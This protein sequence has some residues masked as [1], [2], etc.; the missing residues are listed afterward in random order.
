M[1]HSLSSKTN[2]RTKQEFY[3][4]KQYHFC[5]QAP[6][7]LTQNERSSEEL[8][9][10]P[11]NHYNTQT[12][13]LTDMKSKKIQLLQYLIIIILLLTNA[14]WTGIGWLIWSCSFL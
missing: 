11:H 6:L 3:D 7:Q 1:F 5:P 10:Q 14:D 12:Q 4:R 13:A 2:A 9:N 8:E